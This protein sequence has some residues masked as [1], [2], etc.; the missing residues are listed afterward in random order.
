MTEC[1]LKGP[2]CLDCGPWFCDKGAEHCY[3]ENCWGIKYPYG[4]KYEP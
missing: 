3:C 4:I 1:A 2:N